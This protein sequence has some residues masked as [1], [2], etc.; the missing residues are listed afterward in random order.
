MLSDSLFE[1][2]Q[3]ILREISH[4]SEPPFEVDYPNSQKQNLILALYH[5][6]LA[7]MAFNSFEHP[8]NHTWNT[9]DKLAAM[10]RAT[11]E[12]ENAVNKIES[13]ED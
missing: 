4:Y 8:D 5:L 10:G 12:Y 7:Q 1:C 6:T 11:A 13:D 3:Q 2:R 9:K